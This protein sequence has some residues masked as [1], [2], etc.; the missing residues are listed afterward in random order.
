M[1]IKFDLSAIFSP[2]RTVIVQDFKESILCKIINTIESNV[3]NGVDIEEL[4][5][6]TG[7]SRRY[8]QILF[9][10]SIGIPLGRYIRYRRIMRAATLLRLTSAPIIEIAFRLNFDSQQTFTREF[11][12][13]T[14][15]TPKLYRKNNEWD[16][17]VYNMNWP[18]NISPLCRPEICELDAGTIFGYQ[19]AY[20]E[21]VPYKRIMGDFRW[22]NIFQ[23]KELKKEDI[24]LLTEISPGMRSSHTVSICTSI[25][26]KSCK[27]GNCGTP[28][29]YTNGL[30]AK[31]RFSGDKEGYHEHLLNIYYRYLPFW[32]IN[33]REGQD[34]E[35]ILY[36]NGSLENTFQCITYIPVKI[37]PDNN[38]FNL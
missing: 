14:G 16:L 13:A 7:Y 1:A 28:Y 30:Y 20:E 25:G 22:E 31:F 12:K 5:N 9:K 23:Q 6:I 36:E 21:P 8:I 38:M 15:V 37:K 11:K 18:K 27:T 35:R 26:T 3:E 29:S 34:I 19:I 10:D 17:S 32:G 4:V 24:W 33:R 2:P